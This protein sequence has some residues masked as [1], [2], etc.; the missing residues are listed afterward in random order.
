MHELVI[1]IGP[2]YDNVT[3]SESSQFRSPH[4]HV[5]HVGPKS[6]VSLTI[7]SPV[8][9]SDITSIRKAFPAMHVVE[10]IGNQIDVIMHQ[11]YVQP[12]PVL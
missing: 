6:V 3:Q 7:N 8:G 11:Q 4:S 12:D 2:K 10:G 5:S 9:E 1:T